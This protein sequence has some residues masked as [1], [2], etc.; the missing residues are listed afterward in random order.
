MPKTASI[1]TEA[2]VA[3]TPM[4]HGISFAGTMEINGLDLS[5]NPRRVKGIQKS[6][7]NYFPQF[8]EAS[9]AGTETWAGLRPCSPD[10]LPYIGKT[11]K[12]DNLIVA[13]GHAMLGVSLGPITGQLV[14]EI[15]NE[16]KPHIDDTLLKVD[17]FG[18]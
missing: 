10:G 17:R 8:S 6:I 9:F 4:Q 11:N 12:F 16:E 1:L 5:I 13:T 15:A 7:P 14:A 3:V 18:W 2:R